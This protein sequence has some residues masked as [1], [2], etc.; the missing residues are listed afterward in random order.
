M[1]VGS[2][3]QAFPATG[4]SCSLHRGSLTPLS[5]SLQTDPGSSSGR[6]SLGL[7]ILGKLSRNVKGAQGHGVQPA[8]RCVS[9]RSISGELTQYG[10]KTNRGLCL[11]PDLNLSL[12][13]QTFQVLSAPHSAPLASYVLHSRGRGLGHPWGSWDGDRKQ[14]PVEAR[15]TW[16]GL[17]TWK[18][19]SLWALVL[20]GSFAAAPRGAL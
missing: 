12:S 15:S 5:C 6:R 2:G 14:G 8:Q 11:P 20:P 13:Q 18:Y 9:N 10:E 17:V 1:G 19:L 7:S 4:A 3:A 16:C